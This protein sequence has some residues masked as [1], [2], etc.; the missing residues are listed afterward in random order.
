M[1]KYL[2]VAGTP[3]ALNSGNYTVSVQSGGYIKLNTGVAAGTVFVTGDLV[4][5]GNFTR[6]ET[7]DTVITDRVITLNQGDDGSNG[8][9]GTEKFSGLEINRGSIANVYF[10]YDEDISGFIIYDQSSNL[11]KLR[12]SGLDT[13]GAS[14]LLTPGNPSTGTG[15]APTVSVQNVVNYEY[16]TFE[17]DIGGNINGALRNPDAL[18]NVQ[19]VADY[20]AYNFANVFL[21]QIGDGSL[22]VTSITIEDEE[23]TSNP[24]VI[25]FA[26]DNNTVSQLYADR[27]EFDEIRFAGTTIETLSS[28]AD[29]VL[30]APGVGGVKIEDS[31]VLT[32]VPGVDDVSPENLEPLYTSEGI[33]LYASAQSNGKTGLFFVNK[34]QTRDELISKNRSLLFSMLF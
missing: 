2:N 7:T 14:L 20:V 11:Q 3:G 10:G 23:T 19:G 28:D 8:I 1:S 5:E 30:R 32:S 22:S 24:S 29:L 16:G 27:W 12:T 26:I 34:E 21:S 15:A 9:Q 31:L 4:V 17:Y 13:G 33:K 18:T 25:K 6:L